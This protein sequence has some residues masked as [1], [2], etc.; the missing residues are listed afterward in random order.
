[1]GKKKRK[2]AQENKQTK[3]K[4]HG[5][6]SKNELICKTL[7]IKVSAKWRNVNAETRDE[8]KRARTTEND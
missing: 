6:K 2:Q 5:K 8:R 4:M 3:N 1:M 7:W